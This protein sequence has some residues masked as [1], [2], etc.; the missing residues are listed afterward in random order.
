[1]QISKHLHCRTALAHR[2]CRAPLLG[3]PRTRQRRRRMRAA[4]ISSSPA[5]WACLFQRRLRHAANT[6]VLLGLSPSAWRRRFQVHRQPALYAHHRPRPGGVR[7]ARAIPSSSTAAHRLPPDMR[8]G[9]GDLNLSA[10]LH[11]SAGI[12]DDFEV[13]LTGLTKLPTGP[14]RRRLNTARAISA[15]HRCLAPVR[16]LGALRHRRLSG[17]WQAR[18]LHA[19]QHHLGLGRHQPD[20]E[21]QSGGRRVLRI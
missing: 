9:W 14:A 4:P 21:R 15:Q 19:L 20:A 5:R 8:T 16:D 18:R 6:D 7:L 2:C 11:H 1:M 17:P 3:W 10:S 13:R 12:L